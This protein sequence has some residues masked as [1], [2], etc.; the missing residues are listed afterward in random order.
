M[1]KQL[2]R[3]DDFEI[4]R[5][6]LASLS[7]TE[8]KELFWRLAD[9]CVDPLVSLAKENTSPSIE[10][11]VLLRMGFSSLEAKTIVDLAIEHQ[12]IGKGVGHLVYRYS[13]LTNQNNRLAGLEL[14]KGIG[15][16]SVRTSFGGKHHESK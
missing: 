16:E 6:H 9:A 14:M 2:P 13:I 15:W 10:R 12:L 11:S 5:K 3:I 1:E 7:D 8:L 4:R